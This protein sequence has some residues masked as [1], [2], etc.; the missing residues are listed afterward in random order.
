M[1][2]EGLVLARRRVARLLVGLSGLGLGAA[3]ASSVVGLLRVQ[4]ARSAEALAAP[5]VVHA[6]AAADAHENR[7]RPRDARK[8]RAPIDA[9]PAL[10]STRAWPPEPPSPRELDRPRFAESMVRLCDARG[11][12]DDVRHTYAPLIAESAVHFG[13]DPFLVAALVSRASAC[14]SSGDHGL[15][16]LLPEL[17]APSLHAGSYEYAA[18]ENDRWI[19][20][21]IA[22]G[23]HRFDETSL[24]SPREHLYF[25]SAF[26]VAWESQHRGIDAAFVESSHRHYVSHYVFG[27]E[28]RSSR[29]EEWILVERR[30]MLEYYDAIDAPA[31]ASYRGVLLGS[32]LDGAPRLVVSDVGEPRGNGTREHRGVDFESTIGEPVRAAA[33]GVVVFSGIDLPGSAH[34]HVELEDQRAIDRDELGHGGLYVC[35]QHRGEPDLIETCYMHLSRIAVRRGR[36]VSRG[37]LVGHVGS[38]GSSSM[39]PHLHFEIHTREGVKSA[40]EVMRGLALGRGR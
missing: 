21:R 14:G 8:P 11:R 7:H 5:T 37:E 34:R 31:P 15:T 26:L 6:S 32:P 40:L 2:R 12:E 19:S 33:D 4:G 22:V 9:F 20:K 24:A 16:G 23:A 18:L 29:P 39:G 17:Y 38:T 30:R 25:A 36:I 1:T 28:V 35:I 13:A 3:L 27:D 10:V